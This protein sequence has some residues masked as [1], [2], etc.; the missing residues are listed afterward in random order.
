MCS[1]CLLNIHRWCVRPL[2]EE[3][4]GPL[5]KDKPNDRIS[6]L[7]DRIRPERE[8]RRKPS[9]LH[10]ECAAFWVNAET[11]YSTRV[12]FFTV[13][14]I[15]KPSEERDELGNSFTDGD[16]GECR[17]FILFFKQFLFQNFQRIVY[18]VSP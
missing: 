11:N 6:K 5:K 15:K 17:F 1:A 18:F 10:C 9:N 2:E 14:K 8:A 13:D 3:C 16:S 12:F 7:M 4:P